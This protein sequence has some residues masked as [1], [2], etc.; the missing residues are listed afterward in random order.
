MPRLSGHPALPA[1][2]P[3]GRG[4]PETS[5]DQVTPD[6]VASWTE[7][8]KSPSRRFPVTV[9]HLPVTR[10]QLCHRAVACR[11]GAISQALTGHYRRAHRGALDPG[12]PV[13]GPAAIRA[14][15]AGD[16][17]V[18]LPGSAAP[19]GRARAGRRVPAAHHGEGAGPPAVAGRGRLPAVRRAGDGAQPGNR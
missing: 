1:S 3:A 7:M 17:V 8:S 5:T 15:T 18:V 11:P 13:A 10:C 2:A 12:V 19:A 4:L 9:T 6:G 14:V 16:Q